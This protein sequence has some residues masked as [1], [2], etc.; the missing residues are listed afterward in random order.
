MWRRNIAT[1]S[2]SRDGRVT[3]DEMYVPEEFQCVNIIL[4][5]SD[6]SN[7]KFFKTFQ[8]ADLTNL[9][10]PTGKSTPT[11]AVRFS[12][13]ARKQRKIIVNFR[14]D[15]SI[16]RVREITTKKKH[17]LISIGR[18]FLYPLY[19]RSNSWKSEKDKKKKNREIQQIKTLF[20][21]QTQLGENRLLNTDDFYE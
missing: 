7:L 5:Y 21:L 6:F 12:V 14:T 9:G 8:A 18:N 3:I 4:F 16:N 10:K 13:P 1:Y 19:G 11:N 15:G 2:Q 20:V 17:S